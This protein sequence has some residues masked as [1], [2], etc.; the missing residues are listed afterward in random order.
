GTE[1]I[2]MYRNV[3][4]EE[5]GKPPR[6]LGHAQDVTERVRAEHSLKESERRFRLLADTA[7]VLIWMS[8]P[9]GH[10]A[11]LNRPWLDFT[12]RAP[13][14]QL[15][16][17]WIESIHPDDRPRFL[18]A[19]REAL[20]AHTPFQVECR[21]RRAD[22]EARWALGRRRRGVETDGGAGGC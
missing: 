19:Y 7:P 18:E 21:R 22:G 1:R 14:A 16:E 2:W 20:A 15:G 10:C 8:D 6:V 3:R 9:T 13:E 12:G 4:Y 11:F 5:R 17:G